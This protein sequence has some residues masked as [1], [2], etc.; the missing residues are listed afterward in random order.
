M[1]A[2]RYSFKSNTFSFIEPLFNADNDDEMSYFN[3]KKEKVLT[4]LIR[5]NFDNDLLDGRKEIRHA[6]E[7]VSNEEVFIDRASISN[8]RNLDNEL[9]LTIYLND[10]F[11]MP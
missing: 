9:V 5:P 6:L 2:C 4:Y 8:E 3:S 7:D 1:K 11:R 10:D